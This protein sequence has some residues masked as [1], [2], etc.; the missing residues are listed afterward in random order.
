[1]VRTGFYRNN[2]HLRAHLVQKADK[3][4]LLLKC[5]MDPE[6]PPR[7][8]IVYVT[9]RFLIQLFILGLYKY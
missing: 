7:S 2:L 4:E 5:L 3:Q 1:M 8:T 6:R 9:Y